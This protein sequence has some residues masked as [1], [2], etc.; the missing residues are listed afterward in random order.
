M[1]GSPCFAVTGRPQN[2]L[3]A[4]G[5]P[6]V[7]ENALDCKPTNDGGGT[8]RLFRIDVLILHH[9]SESSYQL[10]R[11]PMRLR[12]GFEKENSMFDS[13]IMPV[14]SWLPRIKS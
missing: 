6:L 11:L 5:L 2:T 7:T 12:Y 14:L 13:H 9:C 3:G 10:K 1:P 4:L 8:L